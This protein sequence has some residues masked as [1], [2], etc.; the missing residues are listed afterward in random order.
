MGSLSD[1]ICRD[2]KRG[3][4]VSLAVC[5]VGALCLAGCDE[6][7]PDP[8]TQIGANPDLPAQQRYLVP[9]M[10]VAAVVGWNQGEA[11][12]VADG[13]QIKAVAVGLQHPR[14]LYVLPNGD[15][16]VIESKAPGT[17]PIKRPKDFI[18]K[19]VESWATSGGDTGESNRIT[20]LR[21]ADGDGVPEVKSVFLDHLNS[22]SAWHS[23]EMN[24]T[25]QTPMPL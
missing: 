17:E 9:P 19:W 21:D 7:A 8:K 6:S 13:L 3:L 25:S 24:F 10:H 5:F 4:A 22:R 18:M 14:S 11:P 16:L 20:L 15:I 2:R 23:L 12:T 1:L